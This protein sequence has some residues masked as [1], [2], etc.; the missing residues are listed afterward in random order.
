[1]SA[2]TD[3]GD[4]I[5]SATNPTESGRCATIA[6]NVIEGERQFGNL[7]DRKFPTRRQPVNDPASTNNR[8]FGA[9]DDRGRP[10]HCRRGFTFTSEIRHSADLPIRS[11]ALSLLARRWKETSARR[12]L[13]R[14]SKFDTV[15][16][17]H[18]LRAVGG[19]FN[20]RRK[21]FDLQAQGPANAATDPVVRPLPMPD[22]LSPNSGAG[23]ACVSCSR[24]HIPP[25][26][27]GVV[28]DGSIRAWMNKDAEP[29][30]ATR[31]ASVAA[32]IVGAFTNN[33]RP[34][35]QTHQN[36]TH[37]QPAD[38]SAPGPTPAPDPPFR[39]KRH[40]PADLT[41]RVLTRRNGWRISA[42]SSKLITIHNGRWPI[43]LLA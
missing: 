37:P 39:G 3:P 2:N 11:R 31:S 7:A 33:S 26:R 36:S 41:L 23:T 14:E 5:A 42:Q 30:Q 22:S 40:D 1:M 34:W 29:D 16:R 18:R 43:F 6:D 12:L 13:G 32:G 15:E 20:P 27:S 21:Q 17:D 24:V 19:S 35:K 8:Q 9:V 4:S 25:R 10:K 28:R 38:T